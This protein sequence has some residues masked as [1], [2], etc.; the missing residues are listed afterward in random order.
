MRKL[1]ESNVFD[2]NEYYD[3]DGNFHRILIDED[4]GEILDM[5]MD[6]NEDN[7]YEDNNYEDT[8]YPDVD[9]D[10]YNRYISNPEI[11]KLEYE[12]GDIQEELKNLKR[13]IKLLMRDM[14]NDPDVINDLDGD[15][16][17]EY[18]MELNDIDEEIERL[19]NRL[20]EID[21]EVARLINNVNEG[22]LQGYPIPGYK[23][24]YNSN[25]FDDIE[26][27]HNQ[28][29]EREKLMRHFMDNLETF[30]F[31]QPDSRVRIELSDGWSIIMSNCLFSNS[32]FMGLVSI[33]LG[34]GG[35]K[36][37]R[38]DSA[39]R[40]YRNVDDMKKEINVVKRRVSSITSDVYVYDKK[41]ELKTIAY[42][43]NEFEKVR[44]LDIMDM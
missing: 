28:I 5:I 15:R 7:N 34:Y 37:F 44:H 9:E 19:Q 33:T 24:P 29:R 42:H 2:K 10:E 32:E 21:N 16:A 30:E 39:A 43:D 40:Y 35:H 11:E 13:Q 20:K 25:D 27:N 41:D 8:F 23:A 38:G 22:R 14:E 36:E 18:G 12:Y 31:P 1:L 3:E 17:Q 4:T 26:I 6:D